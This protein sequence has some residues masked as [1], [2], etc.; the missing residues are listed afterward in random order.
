M[1]HLFHREMRCSMD[2]L[3]FSC[4]WR[5][6]VQGAKIPIKL[7]EL[8]LEGCVFDGSRLMEN[9][10]DSPIVSAIPACTVGWVS[11]VMGLTAHSKSLWYVHTARDRDWD[12]DWDHWVLYMMQKCSHL[13]ERQRGQDPLFPIVP[14]KFPVLPSVSGTAQCE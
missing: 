8:Q 6:S 13:S 10:R 12:W 1:N 11:K 3:K 9:Q 4:N 5:G 7:G 14:V 2:S